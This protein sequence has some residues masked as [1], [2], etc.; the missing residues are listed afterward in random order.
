MNRSYQQLF[1]TAE[2]PYGPPDVGP[3]PLKGRYPVLLTRI[4]FWFHALVPLQGEI[5][6]AE[7]GLFFKPVHCLITEHLLDPEKLVVFGDPVGTAA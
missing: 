6:V 2:N 4:S 3:S 1:I 7:G 5:R